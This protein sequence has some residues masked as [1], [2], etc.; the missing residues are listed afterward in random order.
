MLVLDSVVQLCP[1]PACCTIIQI[2]ESNILHWASLLVMRMLM[3]WP[4]KLPRIDSHLTEE[5]SPEHA[6]P[7]MPIQVRVVKEINHKKL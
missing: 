6:T 4:E 3:T 7:A 2:Q 5:M 1:I